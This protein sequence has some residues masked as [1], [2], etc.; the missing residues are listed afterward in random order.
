MRE[1]R[2]DLLGL[3]GGTTN[4]KKKGYIL[5]AGIRICRRRVR[6]AVCSAEQFRY[7]PEITLIGRIVTGVLQDVRVPF[8]RPGHAMNFPG[9]VAAVHRLVSPILCQLSPSANGPMCTE[10]LDDSIC[11]KFQQLPIVKRRIEGCD[12]YEQRAEYFQPDLYALPTALPK[13]SYR[14]CRHHRHRRHHV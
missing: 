9:T 13:F 3:V 1:W 5:V 7:D 12:M 8:A 14:S 4:G 11:A 2:R 10:T 6:G